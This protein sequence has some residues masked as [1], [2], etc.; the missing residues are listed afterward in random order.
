M[1]PGSTSNGPGEAVSPDFAWLIDRLA[2]LNPPGAIDRP[3][4]VEYRAHQIRGYW[5]TWHRRGDN[6]A[7]KITGRQRPYAVRVDADRGTANELKRLLRAAKDKS[8]KRWQTAWLGVSSKTHG[9]VWNPVPPVTR[10]EINSE[11][12]LVRFERADVGVSHRRVSVRGL[13]AIMPTR[14]DALPL[15]EVALR[16]HEAIPAA[17]RRKRQGDELAD[18]IC[19]AVAVAYRDLTGKAG[20]TWNVVAEEYEGGLFD[21]AHGIE[22]RFGGGLFSVDRLRK[23]IF[24]LAEN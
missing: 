7:I 21:L 24:K 12:T 4:V 5:L 3:A 19:R 1:D 8:D 23:N 18:D 10:R 17:E 14:A 2:A 9:L 16:K 20:I 13:E 22:A 6:A 11:G 15:I